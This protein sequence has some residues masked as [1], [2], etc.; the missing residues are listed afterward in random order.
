MARTMAV[1]T[2]T[3]NVAP[4]VTVGRILSITWPIVDSLAHRSAIAY[5]ETHARAAQI[6]NKR[7]D[8]ATQHRLRAA[9]QNKY[10]TCIWGRK[11]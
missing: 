8:A 3:V 1:E 4:N 6:H 10:R 5:V 7:R 9:A 2:K 11:T